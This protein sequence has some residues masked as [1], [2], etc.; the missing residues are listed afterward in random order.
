M[1]YIL[2]FLIGLRICG[3][4]IGKSTEPPGGSPTS[5]ANVFVFIKDDGY[6]L[7]YSL[8][9]RDLRDTSLSGTL[10]V[11]FTDRDDESVEYYSEIFSVRKS[12]FKK[13]K[14]I[15]GNETIWAHALI[16]PF[17]DVRES[18]SGKPARAH[19]QFIVKG[20]GRRLVA[21]PWYFPLCPCVY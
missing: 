4:G 9:D 1:R 7:Q 6:R 18:G 16:I 11:R 21:A 17:G 13:H 3:C 14:T 19:V 5:L 8:Q 10:D 12:N 20:G 15:L 2:V